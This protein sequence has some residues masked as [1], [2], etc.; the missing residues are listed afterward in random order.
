MDKFKNELNNAG[1]EISDQANNLYNKGKSHAQ[2]IY[3][4]SCS[5][6]NQASKHIAKYSGK[7]N[8]SA[9]KNPVAYSLL[10]IG[11]GCLVV[12]ALLVNDKK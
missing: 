6:L 10:T 5:H 4:E 11:I 8:Q 1:K 2:N 7:L 3:D 12:A 9:R